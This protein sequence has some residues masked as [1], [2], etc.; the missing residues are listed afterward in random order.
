MQIV[1][2]TKVK[3]TTYEK[4]LEKV[5][6]CPILFN[7]NFVKIV[8]NDN[9]LVPFLFNEAQKDFVENRSRFNIIC[10]TRQLGMSTMMLGIMLWSAHT[11]PHSDYLMITDKG[12]NTQN[13]FG[14]LKGMYDSIPTQVKI[15]QKRSNKY[16]LVLDNGSRISVQTQGYKEM[17]RG[18]S[19]QI[20]HLSE[21]AFWTEENQERGLV[22]L[23]QALLKNKD[24]FL[25]IESTSNGIGNKYY[26]IYKDAEKGNSK[27]KSF[28][29]GWGTKTHRQMFKFE[30]AEAKK[31]AMSQNHGNEY[32]ANSYYFYPDELELYEK[33]DIT[34]A[35]LLWRRYKLQDIGEDAFNQEFPLSADY[36]FIQS[37][38]GFFSAEDIS[39]RYPNL[40]EPLNVN[41]IGRDLPDSLKKYYGN[42][43]YIY[44][45]ISS[46]ERYYGGIDTSA[47]L[48]RDYSTINILDSSGEQVATFYRNDVPVYLFG[49]VAYDL[50][51][52]FNYCMYAIERNSYGLSMIDKLRR[53]MGYLQVLRFNRFDKIKGILQSEYGYYTDNVNKTKLMNDFKEA[54]E[55]GIILI[56]DKETLDQMKVY[57]QDSRGRLRNLAGTNNKDDLV[58]AFALSVQALKENKSYI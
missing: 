52:L 39:A 26:T 57:V 58:D 11:V 16:E 2:T 44:Q 33:Y 28:F 8:D 21:F 19:C 54:F 5:M 46:T 53:E 29:Y 38:S 55:T 40:L 41:E 47:G 24:A 27:Y 9:E 18:F 51:M 4:D 3:K 36:S 31:W 32:L 56:N 12:E 48:K 13:L 43:L 15:G 17:G 35:Q 37:D 34:I 1:T 49:K 20:I 6:A 50:G 30:I 42:G 45:P 23:E 14:R 22:S 25:C 10:K 7:A